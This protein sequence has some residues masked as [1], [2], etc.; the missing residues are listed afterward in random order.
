MCVLVNLFVCMLPH[1]C[2]FSFAMACLNPS[3]PSS[4]QALRKPSPR[5]NTSHRSLHPKGKRHSASR[6]FRNTL[7]NFTFRSVALWCSTKASVC[8]CLHRHVHVCA[9][10]RLCPCPLAPLIPVCCLLLTLPCPPGLAVHF[11][12]NRLSISFT[13]FSTR[14][15]TSGTSS[16]ASG[17]IQSAASSSASTSAST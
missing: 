17:S 13:T 10:S 4:T 3:S 7:A 2:C 9:C 11:L 16:M 8:M 12:R 1:G 5:R 6:R 15:I 14:Q